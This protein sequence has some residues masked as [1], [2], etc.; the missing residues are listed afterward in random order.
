MGR[1][2]LPDDP[3]RRRRLAAAA[4]PPPPAPRKVPRERYGE[5]ARLCQRHSQAEVAAMLGVSQAT[6]W[7]I[8]RCQRPVE[9]AGH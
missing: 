5:V 2:D 9:A 3:A 7:R 4:P 8:V 6:V 1:A